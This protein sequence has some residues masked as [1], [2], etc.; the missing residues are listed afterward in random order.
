MLNA[1]ISGRPEAT[2]AGGV[3]DIDTKP[4]FPPVGSTYG[5][6]AKDDDDAYVQMEDGDDQQDRPPRD[7]GYAQSI[8]STVLTADGLAD[9][10]GFWIICSVVLIGDMNRGVLFPIMWPLV[11]ELGGNTV[12]L[13]YAVG[14]FSFGRIISSPTLGKWSIEKGYSKTLVTST[15]IMIVGCLFF[16]QVYRIGSLFFL[17]FSQIILGVGSGTLGVTRAYVAEITAT[18]QRTTYIAM[19]TAVQYGGFTVT[20]IFGALFSYLLEGKRYEVGFLVF[21][22]YSAAAYF[23]AFLC[24]MSLF[25]LLTGFQARYRHAPKA[26]KKSKARLEQDEVANRMTFTG[27]TVYNAALL[28]CMLLNVSTKGSIGSFET[29]GIAFAESH[30]GLSPSTA[31]FIVS[32]NGIIGV[33]C[34]LSMGF[35]GRFLTDIQM[36]IGGIFVCVAGIISFSMLESVENGA[37]NSI[38]HYAIGI[39]LIYGI[40]YPIGH[41]A[42]IG[43]FSKVVGRRPQG[44]LQGWFASAGSLARILF[45]LM[46]GYIAYYDDITTV[47]IVLSV[48]LLISNVFVALTF[49]LTF[50][51][52]PGLLGAAFPTVLPVVFPGCIAGFDGAAAAGAP[53]AGAAGKCGG[54][55]EGTSTGGA[56]PG[57]P[58]TA[59]PEASGSS[60]E[61]DPPAS[62]ETGGGGMAA[63]GAGIATAGAA[64]AAA[65]FFRG[66][67]FGPSPPAAAPFFPASSP[68]ALPSATAAADVPESARGR[69]PFPD[70]FA[71]PSAFSEAFFPLAPAPAFASPA[72]PSEP[73]APCSSPAFASSA[74]AARSAISLPFFAASSASFRSTAFCTIRSISASFRTPSYK[75]HDLRVG[76]GSFGTPSSSRTVPICF[77]VCLFNPDRPSIEGGKSRPDWRYGVPGAGTG[78]WKGSGGGRGGG[79]VARAPEVEGGGRRDGAAAP[80]ADAAARLFASPPGRAAPPSPAVGPDG[81]PPAPPAAAAL[82]AGTR[83]LPPRFNLRSWASTARSSARNSPSSRSS[84]F[85]RRQIRSAWFRR[86]RSAARSNVLDPRT[87][88]VPAAGRARDG[89]REGWSA[90]RSREARRAA[91]S[92]GEIGRFCCVCG[93]RGFEPSPPGASAAA[94]PP[95][96]VASPPVPPTSAPESRAASRSSAAAA[97]FRAR[98]VP[99]S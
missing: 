42:V 25:L 53:A 1:D 82:P 74:A 87:W 91:A 90:E 30:F 21:D 46:S 85:D 73:F 69:F 84:S 61:E 40:G 59:D 5:N 32:I 28:G 20:P 79:A 3:P 93:R 57:T 14:A 24:T 7:S 39:F 98:T 58:P 16:A 38:V 22:Q 18:R 97:R 44:T 71:F 2:G 9:T 37:E 94:F 66:F 54:R 35:L 47:F 56:A 88:A 12:W 60:A 72:F 10:T 8:A 43:L 52:L 86:A 92:A 27:I 67:F 78:A 80:E 4:T 31:G 11:E 81:R 26:K 83:C 29:M 55:F 6:R 76:I 15:T 68:P 23:M 89:A 33:C 77:S 48:V 65:A 70:P 45:P 13:G 49:F 64:A 75:S 41:T 34:L 50:G 51:F 19:I 62:A 17:V 63:P 36:I 95:P 99:T 96:L